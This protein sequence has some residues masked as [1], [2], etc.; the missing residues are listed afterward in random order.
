MPEAR[1]VFEPPWLPYHVFLWEC[2]GQKRD[3]FAPFSFFLLLEVFCSVAGLRN[4]LAETG[5]PAQSGRILGIYGAH[6]DSLMLET[7]L[8]L[9]SSLAE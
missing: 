3:D 9:A 4:L 8:I 1:D 7:L 6:P 2:D 5:M